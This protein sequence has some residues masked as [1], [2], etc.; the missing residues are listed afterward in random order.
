MLEIPVI[1]VLE[2][3]RYFT[4]H[5]LSLPDAIPYA[6]L[7]PSS[8]RVRTKVMSLT[9]NNMTYA[10]AGFLMKLWGIHPLPPSTP[11]PF[12]DAT[13]YGRINCWGFAEVLDST[14]PSVEKGSYLW[15]YLPIGTLPQDLILQKGEVPGQVFVKNDYRQD[16]FPMYNRY[17]IFPPNLRSSI[18]AKT[19]SVAYDAIV[20]IMFETAYLVNR[21]VFTSDPKDTVNPGPGDAEWGPRKADIEGATIICLAPGSKVALSF[22]R[23]LRHGRKKAVAKVIGAASSYSLEFVRGTGEYDEVISTSEEPSD[24]LIGIPDSAKVV[25]VDFGGRGGIAQK[26]AEAMSKTHREVLLMLC[27]L[28]ISEESSSNVLAG[29]QQIQS[30]APTYESMQINASDIRDRAIA[31]VGEERYFREFEEA[32]DTFKKDSI[33]GLK[34][35]WGDGMEAVIK[36]WD[37]LAAGKAQPNEGLVYVI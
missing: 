6:P 8:V 18:E 34:I 7:G 30:S 17:S 22:V 11:A 35:H 14:H 20:R 4:Q 25:L 10:K 26:W 33:K 28:E 9:S 5:L 2:K 37:S 13:K 15:G 12:N 21:F 16:I 32:W 27:G 29:F 19:E 3:E 23:E 24:V 1:Q 31:K 36:G